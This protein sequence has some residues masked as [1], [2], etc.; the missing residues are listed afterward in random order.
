MRNLM[1]V[2]A[3]VCL[4]VSPCFAGESLDVYGNGSVIAT[5]G[6]FESLGNGYSVNGFVDLKKDGWFSKVRLAKMEGPVGLATELR[7]SSTGYRE[8]VA[9]PQ[10]ELKDNA[11]FVRATYWLGANGATLSVWQQHTLSKDLWT[12]GWVDI[13]DDGQTKAE[14]QI[15]Y[16][17]TPHTDLVAEYRFGSGR[18]ATELAVGV[19]FG[20]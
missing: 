14:L 5:F 9:G 20:L 8:L 19:Q 10:V 7:I 4:A 15:G 6:G 13:K 2:V 1:M 18:M 16:K 11:G 3:L 12:N 17:V